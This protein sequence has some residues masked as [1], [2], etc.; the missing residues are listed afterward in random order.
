MQQPKLRDA[1]NVIRELYPLGEIPKEL[2]TEIG[3][4]IVYAIHTG[5]TDIGGDDWGDIFAEVVKGKHLSSPLGIADVVTDATAWSM[6]T[7]K[8]SDPF[9]KDNVRL[10]SGR[11]SPDFSFGILDP[12]EDIQKTGEAVLAIWNARADIALSHYPH[13]RVGVLIRSNDL[14]SFVFYEEYLERFNISNYRWEENS[15]GNLIGINKTTGVQEFTWQPHG[16]QFTIHGKVPSNVVKFKVRKPSIL[17]R[18]T[19]LKNIKFDSSWIEFV[20]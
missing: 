13:V 5:R 4:H 19:A 18:E 9:T 20:D 15:N 8:A 6:K 17:N 7:V 12:H 3:S 11:C 14:K 10:I 2:I 16:S 1:H